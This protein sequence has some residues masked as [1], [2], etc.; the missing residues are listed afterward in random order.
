MSGLSEFISLM[1]KSRTQSPVVSPLTRASEKLSA[2]SS[3]SI[4]A[5]SS[6]LQ[7]FLAL[8]QGNNLL[9]KI[10]NTHYFTS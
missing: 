3:N 7:S 4:L 10:E 8:S 9:N 1:T 2:V 6:L 5:L